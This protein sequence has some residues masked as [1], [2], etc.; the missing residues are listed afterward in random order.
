MAKAITSE[1]TFSNAEDVVRQRFSRMFDDCI[2]LT[3][4][5][6]ATGS[7]TVATMDP[8]WFYNKGDDWFNEAWYEAY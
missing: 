8:P 7:F 1:G 4:S 5:T 6:G 2:L 3:G